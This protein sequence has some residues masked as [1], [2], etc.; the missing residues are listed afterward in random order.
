MADLATLRKQYAGYIKQAKKI[1]EGHTGDDPLPQEDLDQIDGFLGKADELKIQIDLMQRVAEGDEFLN[2]GQGTQAA[3]LGWRESGPE[4]GIQPVDEKSWREIEVKVSPFETLTMRYFVPIPV[5]KKEYPSAFEAYLRKGMGQ[6]GPQDRKTLQEAVD[7]AGGFLVPADAQGSI[8]K[9]IA[10][11]AS[12]RPRAR[13]ITTSRDLVTWPKLKWTTDD[14]YTSGVRLTWTG[15]QPS[16]STAHRA[17]DPVF[18]VEQIPVH[19]AMASLPLTNNVIEDSAF[20]IMGVCSDLM[21]EGFALGENDVFI[22]GSGL[23]QPEGILTHPDASTVYS[24]PPGIYVK[25]GSAATFTADGLID[26]ET[27][28]PAQYERGSV[29]LMSKASKA[30]IRKLKSATEELY[31]YPYGT[32]IGQFGPIPESLLGYPI[33]KDEF[34]PAVG[35]N[36]FPVILGDLNAYLIVDRVGFSMQVLRELY[37]ETNVV[38]ILARRRVGGQLIESYRLRTHKCEA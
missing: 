20:D 26:L 38:V 17:T 37:A 12:V 31:L 21:G 35:A 11:I 14:K 32:N 30:V 4:E 23:N 24:S 27:Q 3:H 9:K 7:S 16:S 8:L 28:L 13:R 36:A 22:N 15:E 1:S 19:T 10:T 33:V 5:D 29:F 25:S 34:M 6:V 18:D 2:A